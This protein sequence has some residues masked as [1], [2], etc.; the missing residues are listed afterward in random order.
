MPS[1]PAA[2][3]PY[4]AAVSRSEVVAPAGPARALAVPVAAMAAA[5]PLCHVGETRTCSPG[6]RTPLAFEVPAPKDSASVV[7][8]PG[9]SPTIPAVHA[10]GVWTSVTD[11]SSIHQV[12]PVAVPSVEMRNR[13]LT[14]I[15]A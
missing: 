9:S 8:A 4:P 2:I 5:D 15:P 14:V 12:S 11:R 10:L 13:T 1:A 6:S 3:V 7:R